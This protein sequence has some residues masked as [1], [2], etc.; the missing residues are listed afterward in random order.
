MARTHPLQR[1]EPLLLVAVGGFAGSN[2]RY[3]SELL[4]PSSL[5]ATLGVNV[6]GSL[7]LGFVFYEHRFGGVISG[8]GRT[9]LATGFIASFTTYSTFVMDA[10]TADPLAG[11]SYV[12]GSYLLAFAGVLVGREGAR[13][14]HPGV[15]AVPEG[16]R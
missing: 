16:S 15:V 2:M 13:W 9:L 11:I 4:V 5:A 1:V 6:L 10:I 3:L 14:A 7:A 12:L 8:S